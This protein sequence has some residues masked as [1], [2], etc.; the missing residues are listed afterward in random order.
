MVAPQLGQVDLHP[1]LEQEQDD[2]DVGQQLELVVIGDVAGR[3]RR[4]AEADGEIPD[5]RREPEST[6]NEAAR[7]GRQQDQADLEDGRRGGVHLAM[8][9][10][11]V[12]PAPP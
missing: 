10:A 2:A 5:D 11:V 3:E 12:G 7:H 9:P 6:R 4:E 8:V 1:D